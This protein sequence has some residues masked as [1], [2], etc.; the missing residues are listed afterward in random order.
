[1]L[2]VIDSYCETG[3]ADLASHQHQYTSEWSNN[4]EGLK[5]T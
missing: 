5:S 4:W 3:T 1:M 2:V